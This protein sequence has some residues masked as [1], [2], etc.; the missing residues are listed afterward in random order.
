MF[1]ER[2]RLLLLASLLATTLINSAR[3]ATP[4][5]SASPVGAFVEELVVYGVD[6]SGT[7]GIDTPLKADISDD[8]EALN[9]KQKRELEAQFSRMARPSLRIAVARLP[10]R[11]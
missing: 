2:L 1:K 5:L 3:G 11:G 6:T 10:S 7:R 8:V 4:Y 9:S